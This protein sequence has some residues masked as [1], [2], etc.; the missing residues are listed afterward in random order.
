MPVLDG[1][2]AAVRMRK[3]GCDSFI[4]GVTGN[5]L[6]EDVSYFKECGASEVLPKPFVFEDLQLMLVEY[7]VVG[8]RESF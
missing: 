2:S 4:V 5:L 3:A 6:E 1:P 7:G 8:H